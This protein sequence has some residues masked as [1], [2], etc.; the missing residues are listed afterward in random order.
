[1]YV[2]IEQHKIQNYRK[3]EGTGLQTQPEL[4]LSKAIY[5]LESLVCQSIGEQMLMYYTILN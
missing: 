1:M 4:N 3:E 5:N 2:P